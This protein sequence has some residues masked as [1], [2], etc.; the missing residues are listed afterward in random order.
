[1]K[2]FEIESV[3][4]NVPPELQIA[5]A[6]FMAGNITKA[7]FNTRVRTFRDR[8]REAQRQDR[9][10]LAARDVTP[11]QEPATALVS[12]REERETAGPAS[13][14]QTGSLTAK[15][16]ER[17]LKKPGRYSDGN[18]LYFQVTNEKNRSWIFRFERDGHEYAMGLGPAHTVSLSLAREKA[19]A[20]RLQ[21]LDGINPLT[22]RRDARAAAKVAAAKTLTFGEA[23]EQYIKAHAPGWRN[24][25]HAGQWMQTLLGKTLRGTPTK[26]DHCAAL[27]PLPV[28]AIDTPTL[29]KTL[30]P[31]WL[32]VPETAR[33]IRG[34][35]ESVLAWAIVRGYRSGP[36]PA[37]WKN[38]LDKILPGKTKR[39]KKHHEALPYRDVPA[40]R[41]ALAAREGT[42]AKALLFL[43][44]TAARTGEVLKA[45]WPEFD[46]ANKLWT[47]SAGRMKAGKEH[48]VP[49]SQPA[50]DLFASLPREEG[51]DLAFIGQRKGKPLFDMAL[52]TTMRRMGL[53]AVPHGLRSSFSDWAHECTN[54]SHHA[55]ELALAHEV[56]T[57]VERAYRRGDQFKKRVK[58]AED[59]AK[60]CM[61]PP[62][63]AADESNVVPIRTTP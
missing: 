28:A 16:I 15:R 55:I 33:R 49:L 46:F 50:L 7:E 17:S 43:L 6:D 57:D 34:R 42:A 18:G 47:I 1:L 4:I 31:I 24:A 26:V 3:P 14:R 36:N 37:T 53:T 35:V 25:K 60:F 56:G 13:R 21:L 8:M 38:H 27:R 23:A 40:F 62:A 45:T 22:A 5:L 54:H 20:A 12:L 29:L 58:L 61:S 63:V 52:I 44:F 32:G 11:K 30:E 19:R 10:S 39:E 41:A 9:A 59:W 2:K 51:S 48:R